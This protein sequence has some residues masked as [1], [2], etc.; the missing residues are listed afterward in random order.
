MT[1]ELKL[2]TA[3]SP[4]LKEVRERKAASGVESKATRIEKQLLEKAREISTASVTLEDWG[5]FYKLPSGGWRG[6]GGNY[7]PTT[8]LGKKL[9]TALK[10]QKKE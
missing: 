10:A 7:G 5:T 1:E 4:K 8:E 6:P 3:I 9:E 2:P